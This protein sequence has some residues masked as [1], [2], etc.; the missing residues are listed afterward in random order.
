MKIKFLFLLLFLNLFP[1][2]SLLAEEPEISVK[3]ERIFRGPGLYGFMNGGADLFLEYGVS[4]LTNRDVE[5]QEEFF[6]IDI[7][8]LLS[9]EDAFGIYSQ[10]VFRCERSDENENIFCISP[11]Q[12]QAVSGS[13]YISVVFPSG[14]TKA[15]KLSRE[16]IDFY[17]APKE[18]DNPE[19][20]KVL[21]DSPP[22]STKIKY[23]RGPLSTSSASSKLATLS[24]GV[25]YQGIWF[26]KDDSGNF[27]HSLI[28]FPNDVEKE[29]F[30][31]RISQENIIEEHSSSLYIKIDEEKKE[32]PTDRGDFGF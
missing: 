4:L 3:R 5:Y 10:H 30:K 15:K 19:F 24:E 32:N 14:S 28:L 1:L 11:Y 22:Y 27:F 16:L 21:I 25:L 26:T 9:P 2:S 18:V 8:E 29:K 17:V 7:Y 12:L 31:E 23:L 6:T 13:K 20:P